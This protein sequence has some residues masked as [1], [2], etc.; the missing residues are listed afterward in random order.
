MD[1]KGKFSQKEALPLYTASGEDL[2]IQGAI[3]EKKS[4]K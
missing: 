4:H 2:P 3:K 1:R